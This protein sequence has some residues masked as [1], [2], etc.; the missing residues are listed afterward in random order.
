MIAMFIAGFV[1]GVL[2]TFALLNWLESAPT[3]DQLWPK[4]R[5]I[6]KRERK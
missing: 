1:F 5:A 2:G 3:E 6:A 4:G